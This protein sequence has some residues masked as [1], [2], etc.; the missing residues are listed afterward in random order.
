MCWAGHGIEAGRARLGVNGS[1]RM[2]KFEREGRDLRRQR[3]G[4]EI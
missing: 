1:G 4:H 3:V 2:G